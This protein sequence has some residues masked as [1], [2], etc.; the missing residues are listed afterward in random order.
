M[1]HLARRKVVFV[2]VEGPS[3]ETA[4]GITLNQVFDKESI[5]VHIMHGDI[6][7]RNG[8]T[9]QNVVSK[10]GNEIK[11]YAKS[12]HYKPADF[13]QIIHIV[14]TDAAYLLED[15]I[16]EDAENDEL[17]YQD[18]G[19]H[20]NDK[21]KVIFRNKQKTENLFRLRSC[22]NVWGVPY[23]VYYMSCNLDHVLYGKRNSSDEEKEQDAY[24]FAKLYKNDVEAFLKYMCDSTFSVKGDFTESWEFIEKDMHS[25]E[26]YT[27]LPIALEKEINWIPKDTIEI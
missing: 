20:T 18:D 15:K 16:I 25:I 4:L 10:I 8:V 9:S 23:R 22:G 1:K 19:I 2:I 27:N 12:N 13:K 3:D 6:T 11:A 26:R 7:T 21:E 14:D 24:N 17:S 5:Y